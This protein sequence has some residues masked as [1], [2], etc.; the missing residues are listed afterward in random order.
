MNSVE[1]DEIG[2]LLAVLETGSFTAAAR[3]LGRDSSVISRRLKALET[4]LGTRLVERTTRR[5][6]A[7]E[8]GARL[9]ERVQ[10]AMQLI[11][12]GEE[13]AR[14]LSASPIGLLRLSL[15]AGFGRRWIAPRLPSF[16][17][18]YPALEV[19]AVFTDRFVDLIA[20]RFD[21]GVR[22]GRLEDNRLVARHVRTMRRLLCASPAYL[23]THPPIRHP[24]DL[25]QHACIGFT[26]MASHPVW[27]LS[28]HGQRHAVRTHPRLATDDIDALMHAA[29][30]GTGVSYCADW[31]VA[32][33]LREKRLVE[34]LPAWEVAGDETMHVI[35]ASAHF[36]PAKVRAFI[37]WVVEEFEHP[38]WAT[39]TGGA[40][41][42]PDTRADPP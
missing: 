25:V 21:A 10:E 34:V 39:Q 36:T 6:S 4:R 30:Q 5:L 41:V 40:P 24:R 17:A 38:P 28:R 29:L 12:G 19:E 26:P 16:L 15:P 8:A 11:R 32:N 20:E 27:H 14:S 33:E 13:E 35:R 2:A 42:A 9:R 18:R 23:D 22:I 3:Q 1:A 7:T 37:D 31:V